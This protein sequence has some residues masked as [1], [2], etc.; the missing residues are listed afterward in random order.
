[1]RNVPFDVHPTGEPAAAVAARV[2]CVFI[3]EVP[4]HPDIENGPHFNL[5]C[6]F[7]QDGDPLSAVLLASESIA[8]GIRH[9]VSK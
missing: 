1:M 3:T 4:T 9:S 7:G 2:S 8:L 5:V 6:Q